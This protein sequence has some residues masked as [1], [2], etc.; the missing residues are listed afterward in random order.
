MGRRTPVGYI[1]FAI[2]LCYFAYFN[3]LEIIAEANYA[4][5]S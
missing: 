5:K 2:V 3:D 4:V 1:Y